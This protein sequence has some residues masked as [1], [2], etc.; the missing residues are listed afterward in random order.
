[1]NRQTIRSALPKADDQ[2][3]KLPNH[4]TPF[5]GFYIFSK[6]QNVPE[7]IK[8]NFCFIFLTFFPIKSN[9]LLTKLNGH[10]K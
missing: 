8:Q 7:K 10:S 6:F 1:M 9:L 3:N 4:V 2:L 5:E